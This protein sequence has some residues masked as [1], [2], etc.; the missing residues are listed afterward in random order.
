VTPYPADTDVN[1]NP[2]KYTH[3]VGTGKVVVFR[4]N[5]RID[6]TWSR[7]NAQSGTT[8]TDVTGAPIGLAPGGAWVV[9]V[10]NG[11]GLTS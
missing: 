11:T 9:L 10:A 8:L 6:G 5:R 1:G 3:S 4:N 7:P 2:S